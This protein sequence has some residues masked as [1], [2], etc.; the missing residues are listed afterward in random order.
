M[1][2]LIINFQNS[3]PIKGCCLLKTVNVF[4][5]LVQGGLLM[6]LAFGDL[7]EE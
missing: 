7:K 6:T 4:H 5:H 2:Y 1:K 3:L